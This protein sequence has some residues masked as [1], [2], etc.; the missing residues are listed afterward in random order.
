MSPAIAAASKSGGPP[1]RVIVTVMAI[2]GGLGAS[3]IIAASVVAAQ[4]FSKTHRA[5]TMLTTA[6][7]LTAIAAAIFAGAEAPIG[8]LWVPLS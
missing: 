4:V 5:Q 1:A 6:L 3:L 8:K 2:T 7:V